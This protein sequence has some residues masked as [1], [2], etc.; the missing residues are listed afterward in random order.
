MLRGRELGAGG[1]GSEVGFRG[2]G[3]FA[4]ASKC[5]GCDDEGE[6][7]SGD[8]HDMRCGAAGTDG[9]FNGWRVPNAVVQWQPLDQQ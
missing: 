6:C 2:G 9:V 5:D 1:S 7:E 8:T 3:E 4:E